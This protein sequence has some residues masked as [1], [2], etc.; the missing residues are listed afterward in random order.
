MKRSFPEP[1]RLLDLAPEDDPA[2][3]ARLVRSAIKAPDEPVPRVKWRIRNTLQRKSDRSRRYLRVALVG[4]GIFLTGGVVGAVVRPILGPHARV[5]IESVENVYPG[6]RTESPRHGKTEQAKGG[7]APDLQPAP[8]TAAQEPAP[9]AQDESTRALGAVVDHLSLDLADLPALGTSTAVKRQVAPASGIRPE[10]APTVS[11]AKQ[12][13]TDPIPVR[14]ARP[15]SSTQRAPEGT[16]ALARVETTPSRQPESGHPVQQPAW[17]AS[18]VEPPAYVPTASTVTVP[19]AQ[20][21]PGRPNLDLPYPAPGTSAP[22]PAL[23]AA[24]LKPSAPPP[25]EQALLARA[26]RNLRAERR[27]GNALAALDEYAARFPDG[28]LRPEAARLRTEALLALG[29]KQAALSELDRQPSTGAGGEEARLVRGELRAADG[30]WSDALLDFDTVVRAWLPHA[31]AL[32]KQGS[33]QQRERL[34][35]ALWDR[36]SARAHLGDPVG[37]RTDLRECLRRFP[38]GRFAERA[39]QLLGELR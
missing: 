17:P 30:R 36:A 19:G 4:G 9:S 3:M 34:E 16:R 5:T 26:L 35:R 38:G 37:A 24:A 14:A 6:P 29:Y 2:H 1:D 20:L 23:P 13:A 27:P 18:D 8:E 25:S 11:S 22:R 32:V 7:V 39:A 21:S 28:A 33:G 31:A 12:A 10:P 15:V